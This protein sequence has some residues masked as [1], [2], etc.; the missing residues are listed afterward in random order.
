MTLHITD[1][2]LKGVEVDG[3]GEVVAVVG[4]VDVDGVGDLLVDVGF[5]VCLV[6]QVLPVQGVVVVGSVV[7]VVDGGLVVC[8]VVQELPVQGV[9]VVGAV[10]EVVVAD[11]GGS[12]VVVPL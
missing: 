2:L 11:G 12:A 8:L 1:P 9:V 3:V 6:V 5:V 4:L 7:E 10:V